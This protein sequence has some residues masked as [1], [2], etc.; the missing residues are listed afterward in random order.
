[1]DVEKDWLER[2]DDLGIDCNRML[3]VNELS[4]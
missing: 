4:M 1:M 2:V 3:D